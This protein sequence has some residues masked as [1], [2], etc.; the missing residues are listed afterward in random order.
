[1]E[2]NKKNYSEMP[3]TELN[4]D[5][6]YLEIFESEFNNLFDSEHKIKKHNLTNPHNNP[7]NNPHNNLNNYQNNKQIIVNEPIKPINKNEFDLDKEENK[8][9]LINNN[10]ENIL[11]RNLKKSKIFFKKIKNINTSELKIEK[12]KNHKNHINH[13]K[14]NK[15][16]KPKANIS[17]QDELVDILGTKDLIAIDML[18]KYINNN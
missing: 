4:V 18:I 10:K 3:E 13:K 11:K 1:M 16:K 6:N 14:Q 12:T 15:H 5:P 7:Y 2:K 8:K 17:E 9:K